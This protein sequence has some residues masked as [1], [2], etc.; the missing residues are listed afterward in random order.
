MKA[1]PRV[2]VVGFLI[3]GCLSV[4]ACKRLFAPPTLTV[5]SVAE[6]RRAA[7]GIGLLPD[8]DRSIG[9]VSAVAQAINLP[10]DAAAMREKLLAEIKIP[11]GASKAISMN[12]PVA[13]VLLPPAAPG[14][15]PEA[16]A[17]L[18]L[19]SA[20]AVKEVAGAFGKPIAT[21]DDAA[22]FKQADGSNFWLWHKDGNVV[23]ST[24]LDAL[25]T[26]AALAL[27]SLTKSEED[28]VVT[29]SPEAI[30]KSQGTEVKTAMAKLAKD[31][32]SEGKAAGRSLLSLALAKVVVN[33]LSDKLADIEEARL[34]V[35]ID[36]ILGGTFTTRFKPKAGSALAR[37]MGKPAPYTLEPAV[38]AAGDP[39]ML[40]ASSPTTWVA[41]AWRTLAPVL[42]QSPDGAALAKP[43]ETI[44]AGLTGG[45]SL[46]AR[47]KDKQWQQVGAYELA[48]GTAPDAYLDQIMA[49]YKS[50]ELTKV[51]AAL[52]LKLKPSVT[53]DK[54]GIVGELKVD[55]S[56]LPA[57]QAVAMKSVLGDKY[58][59][60]LAA[61]PGRVFLATGRDARALVKNLATRGAAKPSPSANVAAAVEETRTADGLMY[62]DLMQIVRLG[63]AAT[64]M[65][66][67][68]GQVPAMASLGMPMWLSYRA[69]QAATL[70]LRIPMST[71]RSVGS[72]VPLFMMFAGGGQ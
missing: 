25:V 22:S 40:L 43:F 4:A 3:A 58:Q 26:G 18:A 47:I 66:A 28:L 53:R 14:K 6:G 5:K 29:V 52:D 21:K 54:N 24:S 13:I 55:L 63:L 27:E 67:T 16:T 17:A 62:L 60:A 49:L 64:P 41:D 33:A 71:V 19:A 45:F 61:E 70:E 68:L 65:G 1:S 23:V 7:L 2:V 12:M 36:A 34:S 15:D 8:L 10:F 56:N 39:F 42:T 38:F 20:D 32:E 31:V 48:S 50:P 72:L 57:Q 9:R 37:S 35:H 11:L 59:F 51:S 30:A 69:G 46:A 44:F